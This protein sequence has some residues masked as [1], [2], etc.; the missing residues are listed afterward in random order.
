MEKIVLPLIVRKPRWRSVGL[1]IGSLA[2]VGI[3]LYMRQPSL[4]TWVVI[5][6]FGG[7]AWTCLGQLMDRKPRLAISENGIC[8]THWDVGTIPWHELSDA[9]IKTNGDAEYIC[10][11]LRNPESFR[12]R[13]SKLARVVNTSTLKTGYSDF[14][15]K[16]ADMGLDANMIL[17]LVRDK[18]SMAKTKPMSTGS[19]SRYPLELL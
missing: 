6:A 5:V 1:L 10:V 15:L 14:T 3:I 18:I 4:F 16:P 7:I 2:V 9:F 12:E 17:E 13:I 19:S 11:T 8:V